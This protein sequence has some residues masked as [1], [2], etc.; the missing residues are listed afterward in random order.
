M[1]DFNGEV[2]TVVNECLESSYIEFKGYR[3]G[4]MVQWE[5]E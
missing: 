5:G 4:L 3:D 1:R 2:N